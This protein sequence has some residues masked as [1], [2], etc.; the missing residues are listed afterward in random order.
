MANS[1][2]VTVTLDFIT[3]RSQYITLLARA[4]LLRIERAKADAYWASEEGRA[5]SNSM[6]CGE[7][8]AL[9]VRLDDLI[10][11]AERMERAANAII[12]AIWAEWPAFAAPRVSA[13]ELVKS[14]ILPFVISRPDYLAEV[15]EELREVI[16]S[17]RL[18]ELG[19]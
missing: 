1:N 3:L 8:D 10:G 5:R 14:P 17:G 9:A 19:W 4:A 12:N 11:E 13:V 7:Q 15:R 16:A 2:Q 18:K 6:Y